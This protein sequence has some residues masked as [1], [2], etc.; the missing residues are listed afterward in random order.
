MHSFFR[1][2]ILWFLFSTIENLKETKTKFRDSNSRSLKIECIVMKVLWK[3]HWDRN[4]E[5]KR[6]LFGS[7]EIVKIYRMLFFLLAFE[8]LC[9]LKSEYRIRRQTKNESSESM[10]YGPAQ[11][12]C[13]WPLTFSNRIGS[14][15]D[16]NNNTESGYLLLLLLLQSVNAPEKCTVRERGREIRDVRIR[17]IALLNMLEYFD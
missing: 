5:K 14:G 10:C 12:V 7:M 13:D 9:D 1:L 6:E 17:I 15:R 3:G 11:I 4:D 8:I 16:P 2:A